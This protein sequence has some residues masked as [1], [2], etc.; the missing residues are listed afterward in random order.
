L[1]GAAKAVTATH[2][3]ITAAQAVLRN[4]ISELPISWSVMATVTLLEL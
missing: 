3:V 1:R 2:V 4:V